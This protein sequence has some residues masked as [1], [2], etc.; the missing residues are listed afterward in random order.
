MKAPWFTGVALILTAC[1]SSHRTSVEGAAVADW[2]S[3]ATSADVNRLHDW[4]E[5]FEKA[6]ASARAGGNA[7]SVAREGVLLDPDAAMSGAVI[8]VGRY[9]CR[10]I[11][12]GTKTGGPSYVVLPVSTCL[13][14]AAGPTV[15]FTKSGGPQ[16]PSG[17]IFAYHDKRQVFLGTLMLGDEARAITYGR[18][19]DRDMIGAVERIGPARWRLVLPYP[20]FESLTDVIE[21][22]PAS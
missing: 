5:A 10:T 21:L 6:L 14:A 11:K 15:R 22:V 17:Q 19:P 4:R 2:R 12:L 18:D 8:P 16:R 13:I 3:V 7:A 1:A 20:R 9:R